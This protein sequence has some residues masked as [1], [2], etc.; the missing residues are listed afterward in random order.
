M[1]PNLQLHEPVHQL[2]AILFSPVRSLLDAKANIS[3]RPGYEPI[4]GYVAMAFRNPAT[5]IFPQGSPDLI[6]QLAIVPQR[7]A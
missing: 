2:G 7:L 6:Q 3:V 4:R 1:C 5:L